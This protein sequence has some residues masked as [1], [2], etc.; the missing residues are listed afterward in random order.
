MTN[1]IDET[2]HEVLEEE[3][4]GYDRATAETSAEEW[5]QDA[6]EP[7]PDQQIR[8]Q[9]STDGDWYFKITSREGET[10]AELPVADRKPS[11][12]AKRERPRRTKSAR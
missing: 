9:K 10:I 8:L 6:P 5:V 11:A 4:E 3:I 2:T 1:T 7:E 12:R